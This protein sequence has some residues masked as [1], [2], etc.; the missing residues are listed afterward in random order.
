MWDT[1]GLHGGTGTQQ[2]GLQTPQSTRHLQLVFIGRKSQ[3]QDKN[4][5]DFGTENGVRHTGG[6]ND[7]ERGFSEHPVV[8]ERSRPH[9]ATCPTAPLT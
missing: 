5:L 8:I 3:K 6:T 9:K 1:G 7:T 2:G 4:S